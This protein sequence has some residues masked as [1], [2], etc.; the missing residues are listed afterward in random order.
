MSAEA[1]ALLLAAGISLQPG[2]NADD[3]AR[4]LLLQMED[5]KEFE[6]RKGELEARIAQLAKETQWSPLILEQYLL[7]FGVSL[8]ATAKQ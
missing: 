3:V 7:A 5:P 8:S 1:R 2:Q 6:R 4:L